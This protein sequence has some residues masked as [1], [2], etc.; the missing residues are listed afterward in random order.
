[1]DIKSLNGIREVFHK[2]D[3][4]LLYKDSVSIAIDGNSGAGKSTLAD[5]IGEVYDSNIFHMDDFFLRPEQKTEPRLLE[6]GGNVD[7][8]RF[9]QEVLAKIILNENFRYQKYNCSI[10]QLD[11]FVL[12][13]PKK[14]NIIEGSYSMNPS[15][16]DNYDLRIFLT[17]DEEK[18]R[19]RI[20][21]RNGKE[22]YKKFLNQWIPLE[23]EYFE[24]L[25]IREKCDF[26]IEV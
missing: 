14:L 16:V 3:E 20:L 10:Q 24:K 6:I 21:K 17:I 9:N 26:I 8:E 11:E 4:L 13:V 7:Y 18:Q 22:A 15:L 5:F 23:N 19:E 25:N 1:M 2:I 12:V